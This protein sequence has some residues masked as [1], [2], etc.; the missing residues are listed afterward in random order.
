[1]LLFNIVG[2][3]SSY[4]LGGSEELLRLLLLKE[5]HPTQHE[6]VKWTR[7]KKALR[8]SPVPG[9]FISIIAAILQATLPS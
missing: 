9:A 1:M 4:K 5:T 8:F 3:E 7:E 6:T 2:T